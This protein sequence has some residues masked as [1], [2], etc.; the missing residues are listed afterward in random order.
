MNK[1]KCS[2]ESS[3]EECA[4][5][6]GPLEKEPGAEEP[7][8]NESTYGNWKQ[9]QVLT[10]GVQ[11]LK[12]CKDPKEDQVSEENTEPTPEDCGDKQPS[13]D[14]EGSQCDKNPEP[15]EAERED[16]GLTCENHDQKLKGKR[17]DPQSTKHHGSDEENV[18]RIYTSAIMECANSG[19]IN[20]G[21]GD[22]LKELDLHNGEPWNE[23]WEHSKI[24]LGGVEKSQATKDVSRCQSEQGKQSNLGL[25]WVAVVLI[26]LFAYFWLNFQSNQDT[27]IEKVLNIFLQNFDRVQES[28]PSQEELLWKRSR[29]ML[30]KQFNRTVHSE[31]SILMFVAGWDAEET[32]CCL[33]RRIAG[34]YASAFTSSIM[35]IDGTAQRF[36]NSDE[37]KLDL[38]NLLLSGF[39][40]GRKSAIVHHFQELPP[41]STLLFYK[42]C[43]H[44]NAAFKDISLLITVLVDEPRLDPGLSL[45]ALE[46]MV[47]NFLIMK[48]SVSS[49]SAQYNVLDA[50][51]FSGLWSRIAH[52]ILPIR[53]ERDIE[54][55]GCKQLNVAKK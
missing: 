24:R 54:E 44:E 7:F 38:D 25:A 34:A 6:E 36:L 5:N 53:P 15:T 2:G 49:D 30:Q 12:C 41:A 48:F 42:Y 31:P 52:A 4:D 37:V 17:R 22:G 3:S 13:R 32:M 40:E 55:N 46:E 23:K 10:G 18:E 16:A 51:K 19:I 45:D 14:V 29:I 9:D 1:E 28:F 20:E 39:G 47:Y 35:E 8:D 11:E 33:T 43:D 21:A 27:E 50:D 26:P